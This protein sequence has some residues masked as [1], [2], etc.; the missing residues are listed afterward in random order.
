MKKLLLTGLLATAATVAQAQTTIIDG[1]FAGGNGSFEFD[2]AGN[3]ITTFPTTDN[4]GSFTSGTFTLGGTT[5]SV[6]RTR[7][8]NNF[9]TDGSGSLSVRQSGVIQPLSGGISNTGYVVEDVSVNTDLKSIDLSFDWGITSDAIGQTFV[10]IALFTSSDNTLGGTLT[11]VGS[12]D[13]AQASGSG[14]DSLSVDFSTIAAESIGQELFIAFAANG[15]TSNA[16]GQQAHFD[17]VSLVT[18][19]VPEPSTYALLIGG[20]VLT[21]AIARRKLK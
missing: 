19:V 20:I 3:Q 5:F 11:E 1:T 21:I 18:T 9:V 10:K 16:Q 4:A 17:N 14:S 12:L 15:F 13:F 8:N 7:I 2:A 6:L